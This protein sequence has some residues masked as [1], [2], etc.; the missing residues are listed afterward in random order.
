ME[1]ERT[2]LAAP[3]TDGAPGARLPVLFVGHGSPMNAV[4]DNAWSRAFRDLAALLPRPR[5]ILA[6]SAHWYVAGTF[7]TGNERPATIHDFAGFPDQLSR[8]QYPAPGSPDLARRAVR[9][10]GEQRASLREDWGLDHGTWSVLVHLRPAADVPVVQLS[11]DG[12]LPP[13]EHVAIGRAL[14]PLR[15]EGVLL[16]ASG[17]VVH[18]LG[19]AFSA[20]RA[21]DRVTPAWARD[22][23][24]GVAAALVGRDEGFLT[25]ALRSDVGR[26]AHPTPDHYLPLL[27]AAGAGHPDD[28]VRFPVTGFDMGSLSMRSVLLGGR[29]DGT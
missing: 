24:E 23:D 9:L 3:A 17:N 18:N 19:H 16:L 25:G 26:L 22:F 6:I 5:A 4:E 2:M 14:S 8:V 20:W 28:Q 15:D 1:A 11:I 21:G 10:V 29:H 12:R 13:G 27:Y 7:A